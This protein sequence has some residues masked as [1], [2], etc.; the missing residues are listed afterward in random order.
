VE[1]DH[2]SDY[3]R[4]SLTADYSVNIYKPT[5]VIIKLFT[6]HRPFTDYLDEN[7]RKK[8]K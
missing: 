4:T 6:I 1:A 5:E 2:K 7:K 8:I 3:F